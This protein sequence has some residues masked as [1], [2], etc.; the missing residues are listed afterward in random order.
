MLSS[1]PALGSGG[2]A[3]MLRGQDETGVDRLR[4]ACGPE[5]STFWESLE[6]MCFDGQPPVQPCPQSIC[7]RQ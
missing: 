6:E 5:N 4:T 2:R 3:A 1:K 7:I